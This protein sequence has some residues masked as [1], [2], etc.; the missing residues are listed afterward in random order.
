M[1]EN[2]QIIVEVAMA[3]GR[4]LIHTISSYNCLV[5]CPHEATHQLVTPSKYSRRRSSDDFFNK[6]RTFV[7]DLGLHL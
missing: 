1:K 6:L 7:E 5:G 3:G 2:L 4:R